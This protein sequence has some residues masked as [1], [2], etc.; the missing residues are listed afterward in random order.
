MKDCFRILFCALSAMPFFLSSCSNGNY[1]DSIP[2]RSSAIMYFDL[3]KMGQQ[4]SMAV[5]KT[6]FPSGSLDDCGISME[7]R[8]YAFLS[9]D[10]DFGL[11]AKVDDADKLRATIERESESGR[12]AKPQEQD[13]VTY[14]VI[15][16]SWVVGFNDE[17]LLMMG[18]IA[19]A[20]Q[21][22]ARRK[23][24][25]HLGSG[26]KSSITTT[27]MYE[28]IA[29]MQSSMGIAYRYKDMPDMIADPMSI[30]IP[31]D[32]DLSKVYVASTIDVKDSCLLIASEA[33]SPDESTSKAIREIDKQ[34]GTISKD[35]AERISRNSDIVLAANVKGASFLPQ[36]KSS[37]PM[38]ALLTG[39][40]TAIDMDNI[41]RSVDGNMLVGISY[42]PS[43]DMELS[44][45]AEIGNSRWLNDVPYWK[46]SCAKGSEIKDW[47]KNAYCYQAGQ[48]ALYFG[49][50]KDRQFYAGTTSD[51]AT[52]ALGTSGTPLPQALQEEIAGKKAVWLLNMRIVMGSIMGGNDTPA[53]L[54]SLSKNIKTIIYSVK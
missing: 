2:S 27:E 50:E 7:D 44:A 19:I 52:A 47:K 15:D 42:T 26:G 54:A 30:A 32:S 28:R 29:G 16:K 36:L 3:S 39:I 24:K 43:N 5:L 4:G 12:W 51:M 25:K 33:F 40:N 8:I 22:E 34:F 23:I 35:Y 11:C 48:S 31:S 18:P 49:V 41:L 46:K 13:G 45:C 20:S 37:R 10:N 53:L 9:R 17:A 14:S 21:Q 1:A 38:Q 6:I